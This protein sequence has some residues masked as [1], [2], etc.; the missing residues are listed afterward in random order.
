MNCNDVRENLIELLGDGA[1]Q[2]ALAGSPVALHVRECVGC[3]RELES[4]R[5]TLAVLDE[6]EAPEPSPYFLTRLRANVREE[7]EKAPTHSGVFSWLRRPAMALT[8]ATVLAAGGAIYTVIKQ[9][10]PP[11][12]ET[13]NAVDDVESLERNH[14]VLINSDLIDE[15]AGAPSQDV[16]EE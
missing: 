9:A 6:W 7:R 14:D 2:E 15:L 1:P 12:Q 5:Q 10:E 13:R 11:V 4:L 16:T 3:A 8:M